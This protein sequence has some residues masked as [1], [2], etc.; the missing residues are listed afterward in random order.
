[1]FSTR[2]AGPFRRLAFLASA[3]ALSFSPVFA[4]NDECAG[5][6]SLV[7]GLNGPFDNTA[8][9]NNPLDPAFTCGSTAALA[10]DL[11]FTYTAAFTGVASFDTCDI[12]DFDT[13]IAGYSG[14]CGSLT[15]ITCNDDASGCTG[16]T[17]RISFLAQGGSSYVIRVAGY[18][19]EFGTFSINVANVPPDECATAIAIGN[20]PNGPFNSATATDSLPA[21]ACAPLLGADL[22]FT[23]VANCTGAAT[24]DLCLSD[25]DT[26]VEAYAG[27]CAALVP[28]DCNDDNCGLRSSLSFPVVNGVTYYLRVGGYLGDTGDIHIDMSCSGIPANDECA[29]ATTIALGPNGPYTNALSTTTTPQACGFGSNDVWFRF[30]AP[31]EA[32]FQFETCGSSFD[33]VIELFSGSCASLTSI[34]CNDDDCGLQSSLSAYLLEDQ[35]VY[36]LVG[37]FS[38]A[39]GSVTITVTGGIGYANDECS[40]ATPIVLGDNGPFTTVGSSPSSPAMICGTNLCDAWHSFTAPCD[41]DWVFETCGSLYD[42]V[43]SVYSGDCNNLTLLG[44]NDDDCGLQSRIYTV[45][46][47]Q[48]QT[49]YVRVGGFNG[50]TGVY[51]VRATLTGGMGSFTTITTG[52]DG[53]V[54][55]ATGVPT[56]GGNLNYNL[57]GVLGTPYLWFGAAIGPFDVC[58]PNAC[59]LGADMAIVAGAINN[60]NF[61]VPCD[62]SLVGG[63]L[64]CQGAFLRPLAAGTCPP[65][66]F[67][68]VSFSDTVITTI[69]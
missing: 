69:N 51:N 33:T 8:A 3:A 49:Y 57:S 50:A 45:G 32:E 13:R 20:G 12:A 47:I 14:A 54:L 10:K 36:L 30:A 6:M 11:W 66:A 44:C 35:V 25:F 31:C 15:L 55:A 28:L 19:G 46:L 65:N 21:S 58:P 2:P 40:T 17:S 39:T 37:G 52:C 9:T 38:G 22:W 26:I 4:Q 29:T 62:L 5:A 68:Q 41:G 27:T 23:Y 18:Q 67:F 56:L 24:A 1:M 53:V 34:D 16:F 63:S 43:L 64:A 7:D 42:T 59:A 61:N 48:G 60:A